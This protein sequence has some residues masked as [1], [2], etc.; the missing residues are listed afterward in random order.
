MKEI[1]A[2]EY[3]IFERI[4]QVRDDGSACYTKYSCKIRKY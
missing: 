2:E 3:R 4:K 1:R